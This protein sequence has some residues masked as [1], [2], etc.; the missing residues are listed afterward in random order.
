V[1]VGGNLRIGSFIEA[2]LIP[3][4]N[5]LYSVGS[6]TRFWKEAFV[7]QINATIFAENTIQITGGWQIVGKNA[8]SLAVDANALATTL[9]LGKTIGTVPQCAASTTFA[10]RVASDVNATRRPHLDATGASGGDG[11][12]W[13]RKHESPSRQSPPFLDAPL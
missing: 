5:D 4:A 6:P 12:Q 9:D 8:G 1:N 3:D 13:V 7:T 10:G 2:S 11:R